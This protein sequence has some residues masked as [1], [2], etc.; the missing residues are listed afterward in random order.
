MDF[1]ALGL[2]KGPLII[3]LSGDFEVNS[4]MNDTHKLS[5]LVDHISLRD[6]IKVY[7]PE[8]VGVLL[9]LTPDTTYMRAQSGSLIIKLDASG[10]YQP[11]FSQISALGD[12]TVSQYN[13]RVIDQ[14]SL[15]RMLPEARLYLSSGRNNPMSD[16]L[17]SVANTDFEELLINLN[18][19]PVTGINGEAHLFSL[20]AD[21][22]RIDTI[23]VTLK[24]KPNHG[25][26]FQSRIA[27]N[28][29]NP[30]FIF[31]TL[32]DGLIQEHGLSL[33]VRFYDDKNQLG[34]RLGTKATGFVSIYCQKI[35]LSAIGYSH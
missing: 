31:T 3:G 24:D 19:S 30:Q 28:R 29:R 13:R 23:Y 12:S 22:T 18:T 20:N 14:P 35:R 2:T 11:L 17:K 16:F 34:L 10:G 6:S 15:Q 27:N 26:T 33:G 9:N 1:H 25:L 4:N 7:R 8:K 21:S 32:V 5:G